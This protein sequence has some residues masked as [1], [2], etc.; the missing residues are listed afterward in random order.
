MY[1]G[2]YIDTIVLDILNNCLC[3]GGIVFARDHQSAE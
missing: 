1:N 3:Q 2:L